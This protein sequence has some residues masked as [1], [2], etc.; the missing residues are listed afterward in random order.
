MNTGTSSFFAP[1]HSSESSKKKEKKTKKPRP[2]LPPSGKTSVWLARLSQEYDSASQPLLELCPNASQSSV[3]QATEG[4]REEGGYVLSLVHV[5]YT[6]RRP[7]LF[8]AGIATISRFV[9]ANICRCK[10]VFT[11]S[12][13][14][15]ADLG[16][17]GGCQIR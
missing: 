14:H 5:F 1:A 3:C 16:F 12:H 6:S 7:G 4:G 11:A 2:S 15:F 10:S 13:V 17:G 8:V 9:A